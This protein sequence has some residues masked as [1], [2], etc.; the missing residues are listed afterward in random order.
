MQGGGQFEVEKAEL[1]LKSWIGEGSMQ[2]YQEQAD[3]FAVSLDCC[4]LYD[5]F[6]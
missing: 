3:P 6:G 2:Y 1:K 5:G 4:C